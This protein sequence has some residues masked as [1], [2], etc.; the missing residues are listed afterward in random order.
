MQTI[1][2]WLAIAVIGCLAVM[3]PGPNLVITLR[4]SL[5][6]RQ[7][8]IYT[9]VGL[10]VGDLVHI[11][12]CLAGI[13]WIIAQSILLFN[14]IKWIGAAYLIYIGIQSL[15]A[16]PSS[17]KLNSLSSS[18]ILNRRQAFQ[19]G[20]LTCLLNPKVTLFFLALF[21]QI[22][23]PHT[24]YI[25]QVG[26][27]LTVAMIEF[28]WFALVAIGASQSVIRRYLETSLHWTERLMGAAL[29][30]LG[31]RLAIARHD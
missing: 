22:I 21:T 30:L 16:K 3:S 13:G 20:F 17:Q 29:I 14:L 25:T 2:Q 26:Y 1:D 9:A 19:I 5:T 10:A 4:N 12:Y 6:H 23:E 28:G 8:G 7:A 31:L 18:V 15:R 24:P 11:A 27:G